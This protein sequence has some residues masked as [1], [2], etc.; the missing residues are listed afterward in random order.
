VVISGLIVEHTDTYFFKFSGDTTINQTR[1]SVLYTS[2]DEKGETW[3]LDTEWLWQEENNRVYKY[4]IPTNETTL[5]YDFNIEQGDSFQVNEFR[6][7]Y[8]DSV[9]YLEWGGKIRKHWYLDTHGHEFRHNTVWIEGIGQTG[10]FTRSTEAGINGAYCRL[11][12]FSENEETVYQNPEFN[13]CWVNITNVPSV[14]SPKQLIGLFPQDDGNLQLK[15]TENKKGELFLY[16]IDGKPVLKKEIDHTISTFCAPASGI[17]FYR[18][19]SEKN[20]TQT[21]KIMVK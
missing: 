13:S 6:K 16:T 10:V 19:I 8:V 14:E 9:R 7:L 21:G 4:W 15:L 20:E 18:F 3:E 12:C 11:L 5:V 17:L 1:Y 2:H